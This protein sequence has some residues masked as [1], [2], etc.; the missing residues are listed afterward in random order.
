MINN[1]WNKDNI[2]GWPR[3]KKYDE[4]GISPPPKIIQDRPCFDPSHNFPSMLY[5]PPGKVYTHTCPSCGHS[6]SCRGR[7][8]WC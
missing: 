1:F 8:I 5:I 7:E 4:D 6:I 2:R 3:S